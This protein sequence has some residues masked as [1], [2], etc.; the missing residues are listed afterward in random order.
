MSPL[1]PLYISDTAKLQ[2]VPRQNGF[3]TANRVGWEASMELGKPPQ[4]RE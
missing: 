3:S 1:K 4:L 2:A